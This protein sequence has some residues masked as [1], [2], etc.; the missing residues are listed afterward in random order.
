MNGYEK[1]ASASN[2]EVYDNVYGWMWSATETAETIEE[3]ICSSR[4]WRES[5]ALKRGKIAG[6]D[7]AYWS[8]VQA[9]KG[10]TREPLSVIDFG[11]IRVAVRGDITEWS[12]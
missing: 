6:F 10:Q 4:N 8:S 9:T 7:Y 2:G 12:D 11:E 5:S 3:F 1:I